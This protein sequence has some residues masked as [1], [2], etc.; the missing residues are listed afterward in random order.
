MAVAASTPGR[1]A[2]LALAA[3]VLAACGSGTGSMRTAFGFPLDAPAPTSLAVTPAFPHLLFARPVFATHCGD[4][5]DRVFVVEQSGRIL[6]FANDRAAASARVFLDIRDRV[7]ASDG[8]LGLL[9]LAFAPDYAQSG[10]FYVD[11][12]TANPLRTRVARYRVSPDPDAADRASEQIV[13]TVEQPYTNHNGGMLAFGPDGMLYIALGDGGNAGDPLGHAQDLGT[14]LGSLL[15]IDPAGGTQYAIPADNPFVGQGPGARAEIWAYGLRNPWRFSFDRQTGELW[16]GDVGQGAREEIDVVTRGGNYGW[17]VYEG[18]A[19]FHNPGN[20]PPSAFVAPIH[21]YGRAAGAAVIGGYVYRGTALPEL[22]GD[23]VFGD[24]ISGRIWSLR[25]DGAAVVVTH[26]ADIADPVSFGE[27]ERGELLV[28]SH[29]GTLHRLVTAV[30]SA[31]T[32]PRKLSATGLFTDLATLQP[33]A[34]LI[35]YEVNAPFWSD[36]AQKRRWI[37][38]PLQPIAWQPEAPWSLPVGA[39]LVKHFELELRPGDASSRVRLETRVL[40]REAAG[41]AGYTYRWNSAGTDAELLGGR[42]DATYEV[43]DAS[44]PGGVRTQ[45]WTFPSQSDCRQ[46]HTAA[47]GP[48][49]GI[50]TG[51]LRRTVRSHDQLAQLQSSGLLRGYDAQSSAIAAPWT[52][53]A[54][55][56]ADLDARARSWLATN[57]A[58]C[59]LPGGPAPTTFDLR[60]LTP[61]AA[62]GVI[63]ALPQRGDLGIANARLV[64]PGD[65]AR[66]VLWER[67]R[68]RDAFAMP[69]LGSHEV[70][71]LG[72][73]LIAQWIDA[74]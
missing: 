23:Y 16:L 29:G 56:A 69:P 22:R 4:G 15:R 34:G 26:V 54:D 19:P 12:T 58:Q 18:D 64:A 21:D 30:P 61:L 59:H 43:L 68:R 6:V 35:E 44:A 51:Q 66:S 9:G 13:L 73:A 36:G 62:T 7:T 33:A 2:V 31:P 52:D 55:T 28:V 25:R 1:Q 71:A 3:T 14:L 39:V 50:R 20:L 11:Y 37:G 17:N 57:C 5:S 60:L 45:T 48:A 40:V 74:L 46:C 38:S 32:F 42:A 70:D 27:D 49:L 8:E 63:D 72:A 53:P 67:L 47:A 41:I 65:H 24:Y 10:V